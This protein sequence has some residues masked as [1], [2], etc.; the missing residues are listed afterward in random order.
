[1]DNVF[2]PINGRPYELRQHI[3][4]IKGV[5]GFTTLIVPRLKGAETPVVTQD[6]ENFRVAIKSGD[7]LVSADGYGYAGADKTVATAFGAAAVAAEDLSVAGG[8]AEV[9]YDKR[10]GTITMTAHSVGGKR[11]IGVPAG[12]WQAMDKTLVWDAASGK[13]TLDYT[14]GK[15]GEARPSTLVL[16]Q[17]RP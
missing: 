11:L 7:L 13:W 10:A 6:G 9:V 12:Q 3:L 17:V 1:M 8:P 2:R 16:K 15:L 5:G 4:H 14:G